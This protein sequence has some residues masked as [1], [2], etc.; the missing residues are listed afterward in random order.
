MLNLHSHWDKG[1][2]HQ[3][4]IEQPPV[5]NS[6]FNSS[7]KNV[8]WSTML[9]S[10][11]YRDMVDEIREEANRLLKLSISELTEDLYDLF[12]KTGNRLQYESAYFERRRRLTTFGLMQLL[13]PEHKD[14]QAALI[15]VV[16]AI[17]T[18]KTWCLPA[19]M[20]E[21]DI[22]TNID[23]F[24]AETGFALAELIILL[25][26]NL[27]STFKEE[28]QHEVERRIFNPYM[29]GRSYGWETAD[30]N[31]A[32][33]CG[34]SIGSAALLLETDPMRRTDIIVK[35]LR[36]MEHYISGFG[37]DGACLEGP[38]YWNYGFGYFVYFSDLLSKA[39][40]GRINLFDDEKVRMI[41]LFQQHSYLVGNRP[42]NFSDSMP[43][44]NVQIGL[45][46]YLADQYDEVTYPSLHIR[47]AYTDDH[48]SR[49]A[50]AV[51]NLLWYRSD[52]ERSHSWDEGSWYFQDAQ[53]L[54]SRHL[55]SMGS[56]GF[57]AKG[58]SNAEPHNHID[59]GH[60]ILVADD[61]PA[62]AADLG[63][64][65]YT[66]KYF[67]K[68]RYSYACTGAHGH[69]IPIIGGNEQQQGSAS[70]AKVIEA[71]V[72]HNVDTLAL[73]LSACYPYAELNSYMRTFQWNKEESPN[74][75][76]RD[77]IRFDHTPKQIEEIFITKCKPMYIQDGEIILRGLQHHVCLQYEAERYLS[78]IQKQNFV[79]H[80]GQEES[81]YQ[82]KLKL[83]D[84]SLE[85]D[86]TFHFVFN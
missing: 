14:Y 51:R 22:K 64:G 48:C 33:V 23:L 61:D 16:E 27:P 57:A 13:E 7:T 56:F 60:F 63:S 81:Y 62:F 41:A 80:L 67:S 65:E 24:A 8:T 78:S 77:R 66:A 20:I 5:T 86:M 43:N 85:N 59:I 18:E 30:H 46:D 58:G 52:V 29:S 26:D 45:S 15:E 3:W 49:F 54:V 38:E 72:G 70:K 73:E 2:L 32:A 34:G 53:W 42:T 11:M 79:N 1:T 25:G 9:H 82:I 12:K 39:T 68:E 84:S 44:A 17:L 31:W 47:A 37:S 69:S 50:P 21:Q 71:K 19:H 10:S 28:M 35:V 4:F 74:L 76:V 75:L 40:I 83:C 36:T 6:Y 55:S